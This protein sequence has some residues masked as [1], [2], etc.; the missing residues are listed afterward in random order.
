ME[1]ILSLTHTG[2]TTNSIT[3]LQGICVFLPHCVHFRL[4]LLPFFE[5][6]E[7]ILDEERGVELAH[8]DVIVSCVPQCLQ[9][10]EGHVGK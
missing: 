4:R 9:V 2:T 6:P 10:S 1:S 8:C 3:D 5:P 7:V